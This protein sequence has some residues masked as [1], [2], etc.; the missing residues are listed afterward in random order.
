[1]LVPPRAFS[2]YKVWPVGDDIAWLR[3]GEDGRLWAVNP[4]T[5]CF[6][7]LPGTSRASNPNA[8]ETLR[9]NSLFTNA[10]LSSDQ[11]PW[12]EGIGTEPPAGLLDWQGRLW[13]PDN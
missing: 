6:G 9:R 11:T 12:W 2:G 3:V 4:E 5:G 8:L 1:M 13:S 7:V 10:A